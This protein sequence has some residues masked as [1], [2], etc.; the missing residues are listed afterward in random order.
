MNEYYCQS[1]FE[2]ACEYLKNLLKENDNLKKE[3]AELKA[4]LEEKT[5]PPRGAIVMN[6]KGQIAYSTGILWSG[7]LWVSGLRDIGVGPEI[8][9]RDWQEIEIKVK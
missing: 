2:K 5:I 8:A 6:G 4:K 1:D 3:N 7:T 9:F